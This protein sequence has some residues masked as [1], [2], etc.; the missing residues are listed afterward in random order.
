MPSIFE[1]LRRNYRGRDGIAFE[2]AAITEMDGPVPFYHVPDG[3]PWATEFG[4]LSRAEVVQTLDATRKYATEAAD[5][6]FPDLSDQIERIEVPGLTF[7]SLCGKHGIERLDLLLIDA[8]GYDW[9]IIKGIDFA[10]HRPRLLIFESLHFSLEERG[11]S[12]AHLEGLGY[13]LLDE[14]FDTWCHDPRVDDALSRCWQ[15]V[16]SAPQRVGAVLR[17]IR[18]RL[19]PRRRTAVSR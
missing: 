18:S 17:R 3:P 15:D 5:V 16:T 7:E 6:A 1:R 4:S 10:L 12:R 8:E 11:Q 19:T 2:N 14:G 13:E 9:E